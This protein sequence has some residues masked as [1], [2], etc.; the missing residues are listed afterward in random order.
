MNNPYTILGLSQDAD[1][2]QIARSQ[3]AA[4]RAR[5]FNMNE[6]T[7]AQAALRKPAT[8]LAADF[9]FPII[10]KEPLPILKS[11][12]KSEPVDFDSL[13]VNKYDSLR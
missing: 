6:I 5:R 8:R 1:D 9:T 3:I 12:I 10:K 4:L 13:N 7:A 2:R 11:N